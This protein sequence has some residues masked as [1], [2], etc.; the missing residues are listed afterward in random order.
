MRIKV[1]G[2]RND[3][4]IERLL[5]LQ[6]DYMGMIFY[7]KS[8][9]FVGNKASK[10]QKQKY[11]YTRKVGVFV[12]ATDDYIWQT[13]DE[14]GLDMVQLHG[15]ESPEQCAKLRANIPVIKAMS[16]KTEDDV[17]RAK[18]YEDFV[19]LLVFDTSTK[20]Y[21]GSGQKFD[22]N[23]LASVNLKTNFLL[24]G[25]LGADDMQAVRQMTLPQMIGVDLNSKFELAP[26][27]KDIELLRSAFDI[28]RK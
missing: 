26:A 13:V 15:N 17:V 10:I 16:V 9:R 27:L 23:L 21:G 3:D 12:N 11:A 28:I 22:W 5:E 25:G 8:P 2:M 6:P 14:F 18:L 24:S 4:N 19:D 1:C 20:G 7:D